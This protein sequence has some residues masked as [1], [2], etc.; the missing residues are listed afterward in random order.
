MQWGRSAILYDN[1]GGVTVTFPI[2]FP[3]NCFNVTATVNHNTTVAGSLDVYVDTFNTSD[4]TFVGDFVTTP[5]NA[6]LY[7]QAIGY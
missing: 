6:H 5:V 4:V 7:W 3:N 2:P 1:G